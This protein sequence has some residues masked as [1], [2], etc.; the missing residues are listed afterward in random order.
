M[1]SFNP[2][3]SKTSRHQNVGPDKFLLM[4]LEEEKQSANQWAKLSDHRRVSANHLK[5]F[6][7]PLGD[8]LTVIIIIE[9]RV[10]KKHENTL[11]G[12]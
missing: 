9:G 5:M 11:Q 3:H 8:D 1:F 7:Q 12:E 6:G 4:F 10:L 2:F